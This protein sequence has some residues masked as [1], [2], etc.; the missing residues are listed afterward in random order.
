GFERKISLT[1]DNAGNFTHTFTPLAGET[2]TYKVAALHPDL[3]ERP[4]M[5]TFTVTK[6]AI[7]PANIRL[8][9]P[10]NYQQTIPIQVTAGVDTQVRN[11][12]LSFDEW[13]QP[14]NAFAQGFT[15]DLGATIPLLS[16]GEKATINVTISSDNSAPDSGSLVLRLI[17]DESGVRPWGHVRIAAQLTEA[18]PFLV[19][20]PH[21]VETGVLLGETVIETITLENKGLADLEGV[22]LQLIGENYQPVPNWVVLNATAEPTTLK[23]GEKRPVSVTFAPSS[24]IPEGLYTYYLRVQAADYP[25]TDIGL[26]VSATPSGIGN[27]LF[28]I[29]N[30]FTGTPI[31]VQ[32]EKNLTIVHEQ[33]SDAYGEALFN[34]LSAGIYKYRVQA[35]GHQEKIGRLWIKPGITASEEMFLEYNFVT[36]EWSVVETT[37]ADKYEIVLNITYETDVPA[38]VVVC[39]PASVSLP[40][41]KA[42]DVLNGEFTLTNHGL[43][44]ADNLKVNIPADDQYIQYELLAPIPT[45]IGAKERI[46]VPYRMTCIQSLAPDEVVSGGAGSGCYQACFTTSYEGVSSNGC[47]YKGAVPHCFFHPCG[48]GGSSGSGGGWGWVWYPPGGPSPTG[49][50]GGIVPHGTSIS[51][52][53]D[54]CTPAPDEPT[55][56]CSGGGGGQCKKDCEQPICES[57]GSSVHLYTRAF[58]DEITDLSVKVPGGAI[59]ITRGFYNDG[60]KYYRDSWHWQH[61]RALNFDIKVNSKGASTASG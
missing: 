4:V 60:Y 2:G 17:S 5:A 19:H 14:A 28:K 43:V 29:K 24:S 56:N 49:S 22:T 55:P 48:G 27:A 54:T 21:F 23:V 3:L 37:I 34:N 58:N 42:G 53:G 33:T 18:Q 12:R 15:Y 32:N 47:P 8:N 25:V 26:Y 31:T 11:L 40:D 9:M 39:E 6:V 44:R 41:L 38:P 51:N 20:T 57:V 59:D 46:T 35:P 1:T 7:Q 52:T 61:T 36:V 50:G 16:A 13:D 45:S 30:I 10:K